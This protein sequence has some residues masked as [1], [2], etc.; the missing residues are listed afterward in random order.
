MEE[1]SNNIPNE[2]IDIVTICSNA[3][4]ELVKKHHRVL[5]CIKNSD[6]AISIY[7]LSKKLDINYSTLRQMIDVF[8]YAKLIL[9]KNDTRNGRS[10]R[11]FFVPKFME[12][13]DGN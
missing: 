12:V 5:E 8:K 4:T 13:E 6:S 11:L 7:D 10:R 3:S 2:E 1:M 9:E